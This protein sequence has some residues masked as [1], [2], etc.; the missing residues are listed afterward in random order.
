MV[1]RTL[2]GGIEMNGE[3][4]MA[5][6]R[7]VQA[8]TPSAFGGSFD[9]QDF[10]RGFDFDEITPENMQS[11]PYYKHVSAH[12]PDYGEGRGTGHSLALQ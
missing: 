8:A 9:L 10:Y 2:E 5:D 1:T 11:W 6:D 7:D 3:R 12:W 4:G